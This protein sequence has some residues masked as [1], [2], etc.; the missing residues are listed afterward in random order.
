MDYHLKAD[1]R[2]ERGISGLLQTQVL[3]VN[4]K[5]LLPHLRKSC[6]AAISDAPRSRRPSQFILSYYCHRIF[7]RVKAMVIDS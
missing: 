4:R 1:K 6:G 5:R 3:A 2:S 7:T